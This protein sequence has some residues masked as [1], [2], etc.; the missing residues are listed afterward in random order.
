MVSDGAVAVM[1]RLIEEVYAQG[2]TEVVDD[3]VAMP[4]FAGHVKHLVAQIHAT[5]SAV[6][7][8]VEETVAEGDKVVVRVTL[9][10]MHTGEFRHRLGVAAPTG[11]RITISGIWIGRVAQGK[12]VEFHQEWNIL[13]LLEQVGMIAAPESSG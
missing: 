4:Y 9:A 10:G 7:C 3:L 5:L 6:S 8:Q 1:Y 11:H 13:G 12:L 2:H